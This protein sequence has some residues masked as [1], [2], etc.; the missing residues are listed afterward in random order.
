MKFTVII[1]DNIGDNPKFEYELGHLY[2]RLMQLGDDYH[3]KI[4]K[5]DNKKWLI[6]FSVANHYLEMDMSLTI[7]FHGVLKNAV[8][9]GIIRNE[10]S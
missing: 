2:Q 5:E 9:N 4:V 3:W 8:R 1:N 6:V 10:M 7:L